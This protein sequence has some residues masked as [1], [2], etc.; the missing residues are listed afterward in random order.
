MQAQSSFVQAHRY[1]R[2]QRT[3]R[4]ALYVQYG[5]VGK[6]FRGISPSHRATQPWERS[7]TAQPP[8]CTPL[9]AVAA[10][11]PTTHVRLHASRTTNAA[12]TLTPYPRARAL[13][14]SST[15]ALQIESTRHRHTL[16][17]FL[18][19]ERR[20]AQK[21]RRGPFMN[22]R[23]RYWLEQ[24]YRVS[25]QRSPA[26]SN[27]V[28]NALYTPLSPHIWRRHQPICHSP[29]SPTPT[30]RVVAASLKYNDDQKIEERWLKSRYNWRGDLPLRSS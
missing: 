15:V 3:R 19:R 5:R 26:E 7:I 10:L 12:S 16:T 8:A 28:L 6:L 4:R 17:K 9:S 11:L 13:N 1:L 29:F 2:F 20:W 18:R 27:T 23:F 30:K 14:T 21:K 24:A 25:S 22:A